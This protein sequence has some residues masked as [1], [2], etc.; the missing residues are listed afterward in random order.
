MTR[1]NVPARLTTPEPSMS[2]E[3][4]LFEINQIRHELRKVNNNL[5]QI[6]D[7]FKSPPKCKPP[8]RYKVA[9]LVVFACLAFSAYMAGFVAAGAWIPKGYYV[10]FVEKRDTGEL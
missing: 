1:Q 7:A 3:H 8:F 4:I 9:A 10:L 5:S 2:D 6:Q